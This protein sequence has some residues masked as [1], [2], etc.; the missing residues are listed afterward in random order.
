[1]I[2]A[3]ALLG[4]GRETQLGD[5]SSK[6]HLPIAVIHSNPS[7]K[8]SGKLIGLAKAVMVTPSVDKLTTIVVGLLYDNILS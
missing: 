5:S 4:S 2:S 7:L 8:K 1:M 3:K 6:A